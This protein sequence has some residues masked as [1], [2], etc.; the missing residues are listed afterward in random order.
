MKGDGSRLKIYFPVFFFLIII[1]QA[2]S[3]RYSSLLL[4]YPKSFKLDSLKTV[5]VNNPLNSYPEYQIHSFDIISI[6]NLQDPELLGSR[7]GAIGE[8]KNNYKVNKEGLLTLPVLGDVMVAG[9]TAEEAKLKIQKLYANSLFKDPIIELRINSLKVILLGAFKAEGNLTLDNDD[10]DLIDVIGKAGGFTDEADIK[11]IRIIRGDRK[12]PELIVLNLSNIAT[13][14]NAKLKMQDG[15]IVIAEKSK[16]SSFLKDVNSFNIIAS[17][18]IL[19][20]NSI[21][22]IRTLK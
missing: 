15:D 8:L 13:L 21:I 2:C 19:V 10:M 11:K 17:I 4:K 5:A 22:I 12:N 9:L 1:L 18:G 20:L 16:T 14:G 3:S 6:R 7:I